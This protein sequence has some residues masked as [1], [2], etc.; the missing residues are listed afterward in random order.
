MFPRNFLP[1]PVQLRHQKADF[2]ERLAGLGS[3]CVRAKNLAAEVA[4]IID[5]DETLMQSNRQAWF[6]TLGLSLSTDQIAGAHAMRMD[7]LTGHPGTLEI[8]LFGARSP[9]IFAVPSEGE[10]AFRALVADY[11]MREREYDDI[12]EW[13]SAFAPPFEPCDCCKS[14]IESRRARAHTHPLAPILADAIHSSLDLHCRLLDKSFTL[15][16]FIRPVKIELQGA[17]TVTDTETM[18]ILRIDPALTHSVHV[19]TTVSEGETRT[20]LRAFDLLGTEMLT[21]STDGDHRLTPWRNHCTAA[22]M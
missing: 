3:V 4:S 22:R 9:L 15:E 13:R 21:L 20:V 8:D 19:G 12:H 7:A 10:P 6:P 1:V 16:R 14:A 2:L 5:P 11:C 17:I 18:T